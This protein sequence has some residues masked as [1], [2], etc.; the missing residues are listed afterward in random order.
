V[1]V[2]G[3]TSANPVGISGDVLV[4]GGNALAVKVDG[5]AVTQPVSFP[6]GVSIGIV[7]APIGVSGDVSTTPK[8]GQTWPVREQGVVGVQVVGG[9]TN[10][11]SIS[12]DTLAVTQQ[13][14]W[15][16]AVTGDVLLRANPGVI[17]GQIG[18]VV[19][20]NVVGGSIGAR[21]S[22]SGDLNVVPST[23]NFK[24]FPTSGD[25]RI[26]DGVSPSIAATV[27][28][29]LRSNPL[30]VALANASGD[31]YNALGAGGAA[32]N[33]NLNQVSGNTTSVGAGTT[34][35]GTLRVVIASD[36]TVAVSF[37]GGVSI[38]AVTAP[39]GISGDVSTKPLAGQTWPVSIAGSVPVTFSGQIGV[40]VI[41]GSIGARVSVS[42]D[43]LPVSQQGAW[44]VALTGDT[45]NPINTR[46]A[47]GQT[48]PVREQG[49][50]AVQ[51]IGGSVGA[52][53]S[54]SGDTLLVNQ[55][56]A[57]GVAVT[58]DVLLRA[59]PSTNIGTVTVA[60]PVGVQVLNP[61]GRV[62]ISG[63][64]LNVVPQGV[65][66]VYITGG[67]GHG[68][69]G[70]SGDVQSKQAGAWGVAV[71]GDV[72]LR[73]NPG[74][75]IGNV[76]L[77]GVLGVQIVGGGTA[78]ISVSGDTLPV[79]QQG[80]WATAI[81][82]DVLLR[83]NPNTIIGQIGNTL[84]VN[85]I[86]GSVGGRVSISGDSLNVIQQG[87]VGVQIVG[88]QSGGSTGVSGDVQSKQAGAWAVAIT[89][90]V[91]LRANP[92]TVIGQLGG[93]VGVNVIGGSIGARISASGDLSVIP[94]TTIFTRFPVSGDT[95]LIDGVDQSIKTTVF[96]YT[97]SNPLAVALVNASGDTYNASNSV[98]VILNKAGRVSGA[99]STSIIAAV[100]GK[101]LKVL[102]Y[103]LQG[104]GDNARGFFASGAS[105][106]QLT[107][108]WELAS[109]EGIVKQVNSNGGEFLFATTAGAALSFE[110]SSTKP[111]KYDVTYQA[112]DAF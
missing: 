40:Q 94:S 18:N 11:V 17:I 67:T 75:N 46:P 15:A 7:T 61:G 34:D 66:G 108:E 20:V 1:N 56:G 98:A 27:K 103:S 109:R 8:A 37:P 29:F 110:S 107:T 39:I 13:S 22:A 28:Q 71:T 33:V 100:A 69:V 60:T 38:G 9:G 85:V 72:L 89:G 12:G 79:S 101:R 63:D 41:G 14:A 68:T 88:G 105:G 53:V 96:D 90:D 25:G 95:R 78:R 4:R 77:A 87:V 49:T 104:D 32:S 57:W 44:A 102:S 70:V 65:A 97:R 99:G 84:G 76:S 23:T 106:T 58:G 86:G 50:V 19:G 3:A 30:V 21:I 93:T 62:S 83:A 35:T 31:I 112:D 80:G 43:Q 6:G 42:G 10:R 82:G 2:S 64:S 5:S 73:A 16:I 45:V 92:T 59:N 81:T 52:R 91:L 55:Q 26:M 54:I 24:P 74:V 111:I 48:W 47:G 51:V 36:D